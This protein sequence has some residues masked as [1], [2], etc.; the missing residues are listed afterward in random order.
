M[1]DIIFKKTCCL[2]FQVKVKRSKAKIDFAFLEIEGM[3]A[4]S[5][6]CS[7]LTA[8]YS[9]DSILNPSR[10]IWTTTMER[11]LDILKSV[12]LY[13][14]LLKTLLIA[15]EINFV[16]YF[17]INLFR[18]N[19]NISFYIISINHYSDWIDFKGFKEFTFSSVMFASFLS[20]YK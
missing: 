15:F 19:I 20:Y 4:T 8:Q 3:N 9:Q 11:S 10:R 13:K 1:L 17:G 7:L 16:G 6:K 14:V 18:P 12:Y 5:R 2:S